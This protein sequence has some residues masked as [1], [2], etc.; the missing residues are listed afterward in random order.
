M[1]RRESS[2]LGLVVLCA[3]VLLLALGAFQIFRIRLVSGEIYP[4]WSSLRSEPDGT[5][6]LFDSLAAT[7][8][9]VTARKYKT[10]GLEPERNATMLYLGFSPASL[11]RASGDDLDEFENAARS[12]NRVVVA[13]DPGYWLASPKEETGSALAK[14][15]GVRVERVP[16]NSESTELFFNKADGWT[17]DAAV[18]GRSVIIERVFGAGS[19]VLA[20]SSGM[21][22]NQ[23]LATNRNSSLLLR[24]IGTNA[25]VVF[26]ESHLG[27]QETGSV[28]GLIHKYRLDGAMLGL[29]AI[30]I[31]FVWSHSAGFPPA[32]SNFHPSTPGQDARSG[33]AQLLR[34]QIPASRVVEACVFEWERSNAGAKLAK[35]A[36]MARALESYRAIQQELT[37]K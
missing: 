10:P 25:R 19:I 4:A 9:A 35:P 5:R 8:R 14:R 27:V 37:H 16:G 36:G 23:T 11:I 13:L 30:A 28:L 20:S 18:N 31:V 26:D 34:R 29:L 6:L 7:G 24:L 21:F 33:L 15:W 12:G 3:M 22:S 1:S 32:A 17:K 2:S